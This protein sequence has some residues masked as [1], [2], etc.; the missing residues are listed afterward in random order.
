ML[1]TTPAQRAIQSWRCSP[2]D[3]RLLVRAVQVA[4][5]EL[6]GLPIAPCAKTALIRAVVQAED[7]IAVLFKIVDG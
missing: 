2:D 7:P 5:N 4:H 3:G 1:H 6:M